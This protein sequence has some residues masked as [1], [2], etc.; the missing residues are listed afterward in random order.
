MR[1]IS[2][3]TIGLFYTLTTTLAFA[4]TINMYEQPS[5]DSK[6]VASVASDAPLRPIFYT[7]K[8]DWVKVGNPQNGDVGWIKAMEFKE[9]PGVIKINSSQI[10]QLVTGKDDKTKEYKIIQYSGPNEL[11]PEDAKKAVQDM[12]KRNEKMRAYSQKM[13]EEIQKSI[14]EAFKAFNNIVPTLPLIQVVATTS[15]ADTKKNQSSKK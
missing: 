2:A 10:Q 9:V 13:Q 12:E 3:V 8:K 6:L 7:E 15:T 14:Q 4:T 5:A 1:L 11:T